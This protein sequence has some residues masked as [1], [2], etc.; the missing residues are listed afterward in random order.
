MS[1]LLCMPEYISKRSK[2]YVGKQKAA[3]F[4][5]PGQSC[6][7]KSC[8]TLENQLERTEINGV[9]LCS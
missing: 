4:D 1:H 3:N 5:P 9:S 7:S 6:M 2:K 8:D